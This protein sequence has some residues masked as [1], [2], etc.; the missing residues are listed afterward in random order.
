MVGWSRK[1][2]QG[3][4]LGVAGLDYNVNN[5]FI[6]WYGKTLSAQPPLQ[7][8]TSSL[9]YLGKIAHY[10]SE[11]WLEL[12]PYSM[13]VL[14]LSPCGNWCSFCIDIYFHVLLVCLRVF[15][16]V[17]IKHLGSI[18]FLR[19]S[20]ETTDRRQ[21]V[22]LFFSSPLVQFLDMVSGTQSFVV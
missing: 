10:L 2:G 7:C 21:V 17:H 20:L 11:E 16:T 1:V 6:Q 19:N 15:R 5:R 8:K 4:I 22:R 18:F 14:S 12:L 3:H 13:K 9:L